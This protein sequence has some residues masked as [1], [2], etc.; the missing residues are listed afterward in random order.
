MF[1][2]LEGVVAETT[3]QMAVIDIGG[4]GFRC[5]VTSNTARRLER[6]KKTKLYTY[7]KIRD[8]AIDIY[9]FY[10]TGE[11]RCVEMLIGVTGVGSRAALSILSACTPQSLAVAV[12]VGDERAITAAPG[13]GKKLAQRVI[14]ELKDKV[15]RES[16]AMKASGYVE[17][18]GTGQARDEGALRDAAA[19]LAVLGYSAGE[20]SA[21]L[22]GV[23]AGE[24]SAEE[25]IK[26]V[27]SR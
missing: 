22:R 14:L 5:G 10:D 25:I 16:D 9:G 17:A 24:L 11:K 1:H 19:G 8:D 26:R 12:A 20:I 4:V 23:D 13:V 27:L 21:A 6:G 3:P 2:Y 15:S 18:A 7:C